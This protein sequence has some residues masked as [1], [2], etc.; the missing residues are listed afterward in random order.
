MLLLEVH[1]IEESYN[2]NPSHCHRDF[3]ASN[4]H[5]SNIPVGGVVAVEEGICPNSN[6][7]LI[8]LIMSSTWTQR[9]LLCKS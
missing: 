8:L 7:C 4:D 5:V 3:N 1:P 6:V 2:D 9:L